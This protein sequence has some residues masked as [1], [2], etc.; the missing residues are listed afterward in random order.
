[1]AST[2]A[3]RAQG[4][5]AIL[6]AASGRGHGGSTFRVRTQAACPGRSDAAGRDVA[7][8]AD[9][10]DCQAG[11]SSDPSKVHSLRIIASPG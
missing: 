2:A 3:R 7:I 6:P 11:G 10:G 1:M 4:R 9:A 8:A 5:S